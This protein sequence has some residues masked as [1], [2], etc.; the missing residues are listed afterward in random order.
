M[1][2][3]DVSPGLFKKVAPAGDGRVKGVDWGGVVVGG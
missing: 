1:H 2:D 3:I